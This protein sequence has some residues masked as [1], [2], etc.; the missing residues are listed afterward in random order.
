VSKV[1]R[2][3]AKAGG[4]GRLFGSVTA[5]D[6]VEAVQAQTLVELDR[7]R[8]AL[9]ESIKSLGAHEVPVKLHADV[10]FRITVEVVPQ[11]R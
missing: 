11:G 4:E 6:I 2:I 10:E 1:I 9:P 7:R 8:L 5:A 3:E